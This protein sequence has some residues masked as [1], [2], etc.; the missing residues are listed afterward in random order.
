MMFARSVVG[1]SAILLTTSLLGGDLEDA[2]KPFSHLGSKAV[3]IDISHVEIDYVFDASSQK[4]TATAQLEFTS[5]ETGFPFFDIVPKV[6]NIVLDGNTLPSS[7]LVERSDP[8]SVTK[9]RVLQKSVA[10][11]TTHTLTLDFELPQSLVTYTGNKVRTGFFMSDLANGGRE[12]FEQFGPA[13]FEFDHVKYTFNVKILGT[14]HD[15]E[16]FTNGEETSTGPN[17]WTVEFPDYFTSSSLYFHLSEKSRFAQESFEYKG[18][19][20]NIPVIVYADSKDLVTKG[21]ASTKRA[22]S[23]LERDYGSFYHNKLVIYL[24]NGGG[25]MEYCGATITSLWALGHELTHSW[26]ARGVMPADGNAGWID[27]A[28]ASWRDNNYP[29]AS[30]APAGNPVNLGGFS[31]YKRETTQKAYGAGATLISQFDFL[32]RNIG[33]MKKILSK[34]YD[35]FAGTTITVDKFKDFLTRESSTDLSSIFKRYVYGQKLLEEFP[36]VVIEDYSVEMP[37]RHPRP[38]TLEE[39]RRLM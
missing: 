5:E 9:V 34:M 38:F 39:R 13:N 31:I 20:K 3:P 7:S 24:T 1:V 30:S 18:T 19:S 8:E 37:S 11:N 6:T 28:V 27:E 25:G 22:L 12:F 36:N 32:F 15:H 2:P 21:V 33:G 17:E 23:E 35:E 26:F 29:T 14:S 16:I 4:T 10:A